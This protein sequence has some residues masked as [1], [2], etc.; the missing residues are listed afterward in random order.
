MMPSIFLLIGKTIG[1]FI[2]SWMVGRSICFSRPFSSNWISWLIH[3]VVGAV[4]LNLLVTTAIILDMPGA[5]GLIALL[6]VFL[7]QLRKFLQGDGFKLKLNAKEFVLPLFFVC[8]LVVLSY[9]APMWSQATSGLYARGGGDHSTYLG[10]SDYF[11]DHSLWD[12]IEKKE[13]LPPIPNWEP[14]TYP[15]S[16]QKIFS[17]IHIVEG[18]EALP[19]GNQMV[20]TPYIALLPG[21]ADE[22][23]SAAVAFYAATAAA[24]VVALLFALTGGWQGISWLAFIP[25][26]L[27]NLLL[28]PTGTHS[29]PFIFA[30]GILNIS[31]LL[32]WQLTKEAISLKTVTRY[33][34]AIVCGGG[35][36]TIYPF[37][38][39]V[40]SI[41]YGLFAILSLE[42]ERALNYFRL[43]LMVILGSL[44][45][46]HFYLLINIPLVV[47]GATAANALYHPF[48]LTQ[49]FS[50]QSGLVDFLMLPAGGALSLVARASIILVVVG[51]AL[52]IYGYVRQP[53]KEVVLFIA[54]MCV[55]FA[56]AIYFNQRDA[57]GSGGYQM[58][59]FA[60]LS[61]LY[62]LG[63]AGIGIVELLRGKRWQFSLGLFFIAVYTCFAISQRYQV[64]DEITK[65]P[66]AFATEFRDADAY[67]IRANIIDLQKSAVAGGESR[68]VYYSGHG[69]GTDFGGSTVF[70]RPL[71]ALNAFNLES[72]LK[73][74]GGRS[75]WDK[76]WLR[77][78]L[79][80]FSPT[81]Q[82]EIIKDKRSKAAVAPFMGSKRLSVWDTA[83][84]NVA[85]VLG[86]SW[87]Y[88]IPYDF[89]SVKLSFRYLRGSTGA[90]SIWSDRA[91]KVKILIRVS[92]DASGSQMHFRDVQSG[93]EERIPVS[94]WSGDYTQAVLYQ[95]IV[96]LSRGPN[97]FE[98]TPERNDGP[99]PWLLVF[100]INIE[101]IPTHE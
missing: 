80:L 37:L 13:T 96:E 20:A 29:T 63:L 59:R 39:V 6:P 56:G 64:I 76:K 34:P 53:R 14:K 77:G 91:E 74:S 99:S 84:Q 86:E 5:Y 42:K 2:F 35:L 44:L 93:F 85:A 98:I 61:H 75:L 25:I 43:G 60:T 21:E 57:S 69:D 10:M 68:M 94:L 52:S 72:I 58:V 65:V 41:F 54:V 88:P 11:Q 67:R 4:A 90:L 31:L 28:Y 47:Y 100:Q 22:T 81:Q 79:L 27:S 17:K 83:S 89:N 55:F 45:L 3:T 12:S 48:T 36:L 16:I 23:Y 71:Y 95:R 87:N 73:S 70:L 97:V 24:S 62:F 30:I 26:A 82:N 19:L 1:I 66:H 49:I 9:L 50:T 40:L 7:F 18:G 51:V 8:G 92:S 32:A 38:F 46:T 33:I 101:N 78:A 15:H